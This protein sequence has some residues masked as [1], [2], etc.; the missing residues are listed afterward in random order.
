MEHMPV[1]NPAIAAAESDSW[2]KGCGAIALFKADRIPK[3]SLAVLATVSRLLQLVICVLTR[4]ECACST[5]DVPDGKLDRD[6]VLKLFGFRKIQQ[7]LAPDLVTGVSRKLLGRHNLDNS[8]AASLAR[9]VP[10]Y[11]AAIISD[12]IS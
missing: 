3:Q 1:D 4:S 11:V 10:E 5:P 12:N 8:G 9:V 2:S 6:C 7:D